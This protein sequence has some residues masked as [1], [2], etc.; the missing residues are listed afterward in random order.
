MWPTRVQTPASHIIPQTP[1]RVILDCRTRSIAGYGPKPKTNKKVRREVKGM[2]QYK[3]LKLTKKMLII[4]RMLPAISPKNRSMGGGVSKTGKCVSTKS[5]WEQ[6]GWQELG[7]TLTQITNG[8]CPKVFHCIT[9]FLFQLLNCETFHQA[10]S[11]VW[12]PKRGRKK[13]HSA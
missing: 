10:L 9:R 11:H 4:L 1:P 13:N 7:G 2:R 8:A 12:T 6:I 5:Q 3:T